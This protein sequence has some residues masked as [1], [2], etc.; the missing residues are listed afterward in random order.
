MTH[1]THNVAAQVT[2]RTLDLAGKVV[3]LTGAASGIGRA[4]AVL[5]AGRGSHL[6][7]ADRD[8]DG[9]MA[10]AAELATSHPALVVS[11]H[12][13][14]VGEPASIAALPAAV[15]AR[16]GRVDVLINNAG[17]TT[18]GSFDQL[19]LEDIAWLMDINFWG[20]VRMTKAF[21]PLL[22][23]QWNGQIVNLSSL[24]GLIAPP[25]QTAYCA[26]KY[27]VKGFSE[28][29]RHELEGSGIGVTVVHPGGIRTAVARNARVPAGISP[30][31]AARALK[32]FERAFITSP[33]TAAARIVR[34]IERREKR[35][36]IGR[37]ARLFDLAVRLLPVGYW[38]VMQILTGARAGRAQLR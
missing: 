30:D 7:L 11:T 22:R 19:A 14:D 10:L 25:W 18:L 1:Q 27:A 21:L 4:T 26:S 32:G 23:R 33:E 37:D 24:F 9:L 34:A 6:A 15:E 13:L 12:V 20:V 35:V 28:S 31:S 36:L 16:H 8:R 17:V 3:V 5:L 2:A 38:R 29:L